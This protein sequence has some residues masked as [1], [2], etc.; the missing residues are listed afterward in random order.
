MSFNIIAPSILAGIPLPVPVEIKEPTDF[1]KFMVKHFHAAREIDKLNFFLNTQEPGL[2]F[3]AVGGGR[4]GPTRYAGWAKS[5]QSNGHNKL[6]V[7]TKTIPRNIS[8]PTH[9]FFSGFPY[10]FGVPV[11]GAPLFG[12][13]GDKFGVQSVVGPGGLIIPVKRSEPIGTDGKPLSPGVIVPLGGPVMGGPVIGG[14]VIGGPVIG[15]PLFPG[16]FGLRISRRD[17]K[18]K[19]KSEAELLRENLGTMDSFIEEV[20]KMYDTLSAEYRTKAKLTDIDSGI[21]KFLDT[22][23]D[24]RTDKE[25]AITECGARN[26]AG[27]LS[28]QFATKAKDKH[29]KIKESYTPLLTRI[30]A[31]GPSLM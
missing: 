3:D 28:T 19:D 10:P 15:G 14:P 6:R 9:P 13:S 12:T 11:V 2:I 22:Y 18:D 5:Y 27:T 29:D 26:N 16:M 30:R 24:M 17:D 1:M 7:H 20:K 31:L 4:H 25:T 21:Q 8:Y 23:N